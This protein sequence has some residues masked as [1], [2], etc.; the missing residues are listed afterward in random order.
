M[1][2][3][4]LFILHLFTLFLISIVTMIMKWLLEINGKKENI[5]EMIKGG[6]WTS[7]ALWREWS[8]LIWVPSMEV[9]HKLLHIAQ[10]HCELARKSHHLSLDN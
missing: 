7:L 5:M 1:D 3:G 4:L 6:H 10:L 8:R 9:C 2:G